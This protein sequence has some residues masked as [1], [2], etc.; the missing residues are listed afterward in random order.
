VRLANWPRNP[1]LNDELR[2][3]IALHLAA[4]HVD[5]VAVYAVPQGRDDEGRRILVA[6]ELGLLDGTYAPRGSSA[7]YSL[8]VRLFPW[9]AVQ[10]VDLLAETYRL[11]AYEHRTWWRLRVARPTFDVQT[12]DPDLGCALADLATACAVMTGAG[13]GPRDPAASEPDEKPT[14]A[15]KPEAPQTEALAI[16]TTGQ[17]PGA[18]ASGTPMP[19]E[20][21]SGTRAAEAPVRQVLDA[22]NPDRSSFGGER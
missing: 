15:P 21:A 14:A 13:G 19:G 4:L 18:P 6:T 11:W 1:Y 9:P 7:H 12:E 2:E 10:G 17:R 16:D 3:W 5:D 22:I 8:Q 20:R